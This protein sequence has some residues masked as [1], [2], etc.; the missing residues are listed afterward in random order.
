[1]G[2]VPLIR[3]PRTLPRVID[4]A[5]ADAFVAALRTTRDRAMVEAM[6]LGDLR[7][8]EVVGLRL[9]DVRP[10]ERGLFIA[11]GKGGHQ[12]IVPVSERFFVSLAAYLSAQRPEPAADDHVFL[13]LKGPRRGQ[14]PS[15]AGLDEIVSGART[16]AG[17]EHLTCLQLRHTCF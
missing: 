15:A 8:S 11:E 13:V 5:Q 2:S 7:R 12:R 9:G 3:A 6:L 10:G 16:R 17:I 4:P 14:S 1:V